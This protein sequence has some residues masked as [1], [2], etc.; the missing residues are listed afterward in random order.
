M[1]VLSLS[2]FSSSF[3]TTSHFNNKLQLLDPPKSL[4]LVIY[5]GMVSTTTLTVVDISVAVAT[6]REPALYSNFDTTSTRPQ[7][8]VQF[9]KEIACNAITCVGRV[10][11]LRSGDDFIRNIIQRSEYLSPASLVREP[12]LGGRLQWESMFWETFGTAAEKLLKPSSWKNGPFPDLERPKT[13]GGRF[14]CFFVACARYYTSCTTESVRYGSAQEFILTA[15]NQVPELRPLKE[16]L[17]ELL[18]ADT[19]RD[20]R[21]S[22]IESNVVHA[23]DD[24]GGAC[25]CPVHKSHSLDKQSTARFCSVGLADTIVQISYMLGRIKVEASLSPRRSGILAIYGDMTSRFNA[26]PLDF[27][28]YKCSIPPDGTEE[29]HKI[30]TNVMTLFSGEQPTVSLGNR[31]SAMSDGRVYCLVDTMRKL[32]DRFERASMIHVGIGSIQ[33]EHRLHYKVYD[34]QSGRDWI[35]EEY[36]PRRFETVVESIPRVLSQDTTS[37]ELR[38]E[39]VVEDSICLF[40]WYRLLSR[41]GHILISP[42]TFVATN[43]SSAIAYRK[44]L[45]I[46]AEMQT[47]GFQAPDF[48]A[49][50]LHLMSLAHGEGV[51]PTGS[52][53]ASRILLR[54]H[55]NNLLGRCAAL[56]T[57]AKRVAIIS[58]GEADLR[59]FAAAYQSEIRSGKVV[60]WTLI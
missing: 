8:E 5:Y 3:F 44:L 49:S 46:E 37:P 23:R 18:L 11:T 7:V 57:S 39:A 20:L 41:K 32:S 29:L 17:E 45:S 26:N 58:N 22:D 52:C 34:R 24:L 30:F 47:Q 33:V 1:L 54:P 9:T 59:S 19:G 51:V 56:A 25:Q 10:F 48:D 36:E 4:Q 35:T 21:R 27:S 15:T 31:M 60:S 55:S 50:G 12:F 16:E 14:V 40:F 53:S 13:E 2:P 28:S 43:L 42:A 38:V 6:D